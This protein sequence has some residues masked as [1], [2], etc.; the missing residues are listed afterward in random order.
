MWKAW[1]YYSS[2][3]MEGRRLVFSSAIFVTDNA[4]L[5]Y[6]ERVE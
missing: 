6:N 3:I 1:S 5:V 2:S 4:T